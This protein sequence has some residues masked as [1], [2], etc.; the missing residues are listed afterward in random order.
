MA[1]ISPINQNSSEPTNFV[2]SRKEQCSPPSLRRRRPEAEAE[3]VDCCICMD[4]IDNRVE[5]F[6]GHSFCRECLQTWL[7]DHHG[8]P[9]CRQD[10]ILHKLSEFADK[11]KN[12]QFK[13]H[14][15]LRTFSWYERWLDYMS[16]FLSPDWLE[17]TPEVE[18]IKKTQLN[19]KPVFFLQIPW[20]EY[21]CD[22]GNPLTREE[23]GVTCTEQQCMCKQTITTVCLFEGNQCKMENQ[24]HTIEKGNYYRTQRG[25]ILHA[26]G[27]ILHEDIY[28]EEVMFPQDCPYTIGTIVR[29]M[30]GVDSGQIGKVIA[31]SKDGKKIRV[32]AEFGRVW[33]MQQWFNYYPL[34][35][36]DLNPQSSEDRRAEDND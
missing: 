19:G 15:D 10:P 25:T 14:V 36:E 21:M 8:C 33:R 13:M 4:T 9:L 1:A 22:A 26:H 31:I 17:I 23:R 16:L 32:C 24:H 18:V 11:H 28:C 20:Y 35:E 34:M 6:C 29:K 7:S 3:T 30:K 5:L 27:Q 12:G 2:G